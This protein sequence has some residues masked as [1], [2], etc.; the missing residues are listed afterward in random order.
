[1]SMVSTLKRFFN[2]GFNVCNC[3]F[4]SS[5]DFVEVAV[6]TKVDVAYNQRKY[7]VSYANKDYQD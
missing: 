1:M 6:S 3:S 4:I 2:V 7:G 5:S